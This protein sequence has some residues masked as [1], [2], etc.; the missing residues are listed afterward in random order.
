LSD[1]TTAH[2]QTMCRNAETDVQCP[3]VVLWSFKS[4]MGSNYVANQLE[5]KTLSGLSYSTSRKAK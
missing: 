5:I 4:P 3:T 2:G 1:H